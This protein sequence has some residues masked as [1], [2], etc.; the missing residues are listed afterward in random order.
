MDRERTP[1]RDDTAKR[2]RTERRFA[3]APPGFVVVTADA[4]LA[5]GP[6]HSAA[7]WPARPE[8]APPAHLRLAGEPAP[9]LY[10]LACQGWPEFPERHGLLP[11]FGSCD[12]CR[13]AA[14]LSQPDVPPQ[15]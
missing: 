4:F 5:D 8:P 11:A 7:R 15:R 14:L 1:P 6:T 10:G 13:R 3:G 12:D 2:P 9:T